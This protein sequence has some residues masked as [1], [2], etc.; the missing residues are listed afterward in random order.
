MRTIAR[1]LW[2][3]LLGCSICGVASA[4]SS[5]PITKLEARHLSPQVVTR[6]VFA[7]VSDLLLTQD[8]PRSEGDAPL[9]DVAK[10]K[11]LDAL[12]D[13]VE[14]DPAADPSMP[15]PILSR[16]SVRQVLAQLE[17][18]V[19]IWPDPYTS[20]HPVAPLR[21]LTFETRPHATRTP[22]L[23]VVDMVTVNFEPVDEP[24]GPRTRVAASEVLTDHWYLF[25][26]PPDEPAPQ[27]SQAEQRTKID[28]SCAKLDRDKDDFFQAV[29]EAQATRGI[30]MVNSVLAQARTGSPTF[31]I[32]CE[33]AKR[34]VDSCVQKLADTKPTRSPWISDCD[35][36]SA[37][38]TATLLSEGIGIEAYFKAG[39]PEI[40]DRVRL[41]EVVVFADQ[42]QD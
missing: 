40:I 36:S 6:R 28:T 42:L 14:S 5:L 7:E 18:R 37:Q 17:E 39:N 35:P 4:G 10:Q 16:D 3:S 27:P 11:I 20:P 41:T 19:G 25:L 9:T 32:S 26:V 24:H 12:F 33:T 22:N 30:W 1:A 29:N 8:A 13:I 2:F 15:R 38:C 31:S 34:L 23:C 21:Q